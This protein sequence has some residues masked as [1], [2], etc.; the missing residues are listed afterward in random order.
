MTTEPSV[1]ILLDRVI[2]WAR[3]QLT[4]T[5]VALV[6]SQARGEARPDSDIDLV[7]LCTEPQG[8]LHDTSWIQHF[9]EVEA[10]LTEDWGLVTSLRVYYQHGLEVEFGLTSLVWAELP[11]DAGTKSVVANGMR[12]LLDRDGALARL[13]ESVTV[14]KKERRPDG[15]TVSHTRRSPKLL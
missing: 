11:V 3:S 8:F 7:L 14:M 1:S 2:A 12:I 4:V 9:G 15:T 5:G 10:C 13:L 6:G